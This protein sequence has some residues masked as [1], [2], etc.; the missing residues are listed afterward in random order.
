[1]GY[2]ALLNLGILYSITFFKNETFPKKYAII[3][4]IWTIIFIN[5]I[6][7]GIVGQKI[8]RFSTII[9][10]AYVGYGALKLGKS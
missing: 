4:L 9:C 8:G 1:M 2:I 5:T 7:L 3:F 10:F 6:T